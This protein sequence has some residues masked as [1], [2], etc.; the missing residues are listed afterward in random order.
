MFARVKENASTTMNQ[1][2]QNLKSRAIGFQYCAI[3]RSLS[4]TLKMLFLLS[5]TRFMLNLICDVHDEVLPSCLCGLRANEGGAVWHK[6]FA[7]LLLNHF[8]STTM[9][10]LQGR[11]TSTRTSLTH[12]GAS[13]KEAGDIAMV[14]VILNT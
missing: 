14:F 8:I 5:D 1:S 2:K 10:N 7:L 9:K 13:V 11:E 3:I 4:A 12:S 6:F